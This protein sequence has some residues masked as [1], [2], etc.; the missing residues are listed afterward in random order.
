MKSEVFEWNG[1]LWRRYPQSK[2]RSDSAY[3]KSKGRYLHRALWEYYNGI[4]PE[5]YHIHHIDGNTLNNNIYNLE[6]INSADHLSYHA[7]KNGINQSFIKKVE[8]HRKHLHKYAASWHS[9]EEGIT[10]H[11]EHAKETIMQSFAYRRAKCEQCGDLFE[12]E[13]VRD[14]GKFCSNKCKSKWRRDSGVD[15]VE[16]SCE[17]CGKQFVSNKYDKIRTC[18]RKCGYASRNKI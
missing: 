18:S 1:V 4:I 11:R 2:R 12:Y 3:F 8:A 6:A 5:G 16:K 13:S 10:W 7:D 17:V 9:S 14:N 15:N